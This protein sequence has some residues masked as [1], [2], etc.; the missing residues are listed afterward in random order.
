MVKKDI[1]DILFWIAMLVLIGYI[2]AKLT[3][4]INTPEWIN[5][6]PIISITFMMGAFYQKVVSFIGIMYKR[7]DYLKRN[8]DNIQDKMG[9]HEKRISAL[10]K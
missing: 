1:W 9:V 5:L 8:I 3:G 6:I 10:E 7:T 4:L 2:I